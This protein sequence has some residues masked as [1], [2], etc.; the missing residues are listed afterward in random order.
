MRPAIP[1]HPPGAVEAVV[2][3]AICS[4]LLVVGWAAKSPA[5]PVR[6]PVP[7]VDADVTRGS[8][9]PEQTDSAKFWTVTEAAAEV[10]LRNSTGT[11]SIATVEFA[12]VPGPCDLDRS[13]LVTVGPNR[14]FIDLPA[15]T[16]A[17]VLIDDITI[18]SLGLATIEIVDEGDAC[19]P[20]PTDPRSIHFQMYDLTVTPG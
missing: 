7:G 11:A 19:P 3:A 14:Q 12:L 16:S 8:P 2:V 4:L 1:E 9:G 5:L 18:Q 17:T 10:T 13:L 20:L 6:A 15:T